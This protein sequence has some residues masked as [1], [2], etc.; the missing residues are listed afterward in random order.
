MSTAPD[1]LVVDPHVARN[2]VA[3]AISRRRLQAATDLFATRIYLLTEGE[4]VET[5][6]LACGRVLYVAYLLLDNA[7]QGSSPA[8]RVIRGGISAVEQLALRQ[9]R[10]HTAD[11]PALDQAMQ[12]AKATVQAA[13]QIQTQ[14]AWADLYRIE[15]RIDAQRAAAAAA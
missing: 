7:G 11:A 9:W 8:A 12:H 4:T 6:G 1:F 13:P 15:A 14:R 5:D 2:P 10:W 3:Q